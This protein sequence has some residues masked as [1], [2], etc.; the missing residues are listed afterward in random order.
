[1]GTGS[2]PQRR[3]L[4]RACVDWELER[5]LARRKGAPGTNG[6][7]RYAGGRDVGN[8]NIAVRL[9]ELDPCIHHVQLVPRYAQTVGAEVGYLAANPVQQQVQVV[10]HRI[11]DHVDVDAAVG[12]GAEVVPLLRRRSPTSAVP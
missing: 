11:I 6:V 10:D 1:M 3:M 7:R 9:R 5:V 4:S 8:G 2:A 12:G